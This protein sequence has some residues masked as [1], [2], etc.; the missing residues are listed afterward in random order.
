MQQRGLADTA[1]A[2]NEEDL[3]GQFRGRQRA[4]Q[5][6]Q[7][8]RAADELAAA[9]RTQAIPQTRHEAPPHGC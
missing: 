3:K 8:A 2:V 7:L 4:L 6:F 1:R 9:R 5:Q